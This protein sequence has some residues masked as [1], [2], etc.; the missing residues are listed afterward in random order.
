MDIQSYPWI[1]LW[2]SNPIHGYPEISR[3]IPSRACVP[4][5]SAPR[6]RGRLAVGR[7]RARWPSLLRQEGGGLRCRPQPPVAVQ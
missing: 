1:G 5:I 2:I 4:L 7:W 6:S 3:E